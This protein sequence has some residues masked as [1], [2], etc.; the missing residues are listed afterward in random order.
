M[1]GR[2]LQYLMPLAAGAVVA[3][4]PSLNELREV[5]LKH[6]EGVNESMVEE[7]AV[8]GI[9]RRFSNQ[10]M[11][12]TNSVPRPIRPYLLDTN[13]PGVAYRRVFEEQY[14]YLRIQRLEGETVEEI[15]R[16]VSELTA[17]NQLK[18]LVLDLRFAAGRDLAAAGR[19]AQWLV[20]RN[21]PLMEWKGQKITAPAEAPGYQGPLVILVNGQTKGAP[22]VLAAILREQVTA[23][24]IGAPT[25]GDT[26]E[27]RE[28][29]LSNGQVLRLAVAAVSLGD[30]QPLKPGGVRPD[31][32]AVISEREERAY[33]ENPYRLGEG[34]GDVA[35]RPRLSEADLVRM[36]R[37]SSEGEPA[38]RTRPPSR[39]D[40]TTNVVRD[41]AL[42]RGLDLL[43]GLNVLKLGRGS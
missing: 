1:I 24:L 36:K 39:L 9:L 19:L 23:I 21:R 30:G 27:Y 4:S 25:S 26:A 40:A 5:L 28:V 15:T 18:G 16:A 34:G 37:E 41:P 11:L 22:E 35:S 29:T 32:L 14:G 12:L 8:E 10:V 42:A 6:L 38:L 20:G 3:A 13:A 17:S 33:L 7:A 2:I 43:K 31:I